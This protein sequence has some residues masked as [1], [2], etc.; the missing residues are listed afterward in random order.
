MACS[1]EVE[2]ILRDGFVNEYKC[3]TKGIT[4]VYL[5]DAPGGPDPDWPDDQLLEIIL[6]QEIDISQFEIFKEGVRWREWLVPA[7]FLN[8]CAEIRLLPKAEWDQ[9][10]TQW[11][12]QWFDQ[13]FSHM[14]ELGLI[15]VA[16]D[17]EGQSIYRD[18][19][20]VYRLSD[21]G[22]EFGKQEI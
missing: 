15:E 13:Q 10:W 20:P 9:S 8:E 12:E 3:K 5:A 2:A 16:K 7:G 22:E 1:A 4:G 17:A 18:D 21:K 11:K 6:P 14:L 19:K